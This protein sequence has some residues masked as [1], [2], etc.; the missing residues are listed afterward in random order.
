MYMLDFILVW[1][2]LVYQVKLNKNK[3]FIILFLHVFLVMKMIFFMLLGNY[4][5]PV[6]NDNNPVQ[7]R[8]SLIL[9]HIL[10]MLLFFHC[11]S[12]SKFEMVIF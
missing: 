1:V 10:V 8:Q 7:N 5:N 9:V 11:R 4:N 12:F 6:E 3:L 2:I